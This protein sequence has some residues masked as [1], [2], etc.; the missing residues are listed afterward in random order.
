MTNPIACSFLISSCDFVP[1]R[2]SSIVCAIDT[3]I[4]CISLFG[5]S[6]QGSRNHTLCVCAVRYRR[7]FLC[8]RHL[9]FSKRSPGLS[10]D[11]LMQ[12]RSCQAEKL[13]SRR[14]VLTK[15]TLGSSFV[16][17]I[18]NFWAPNESSYEGFERK[19]KSERPCPQVQPPERCG[20]TG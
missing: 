4:A 1:S 3:M 5:Q 12:H 16:I 13:C 17:V 8:S 20:L 9:N 18:S 7:S 14:F 10:W 6:I 19:I 2:L 11:A 15:H